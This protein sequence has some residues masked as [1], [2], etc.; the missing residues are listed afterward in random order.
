M[1]AHNDLGRRGEDVAEDY[2]IKKG[3]YI[4]HRDWRSGH[5]DIDIVAIDEDMTT[6]LVVE[7]KTRT[8]AVMGEPDKAIDTEKRNN[9]IIATADYVRL[10]RLDH[11]AVRYDT[12]S[13]TGTPDGGFTIEHKEDA[14]DVTS[15]YQ[16]TDRQRKSAYYN[17]RPGC[18]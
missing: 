17:K 3:W 18:W 5:R 10:F 1:A 7:V 15:R 11:L 12:I 6:L 16:F 9:I 13:V 2:L 8:T 4:R 14:F